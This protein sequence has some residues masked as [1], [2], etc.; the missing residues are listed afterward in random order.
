MAK[1]KTAP[2]SLSQ[3]DNTQIQQFLEHY[4]QFAENL[5]TGTSQ[6]QAE[7]VL[8]EINNLSEAA[9][10]GLLK[11][12]VQER[13]IDAA[14]I[15][16]AINELSPNKNV[17][18]EAKRALIQLQEKKVFPGWRPPLDQMPAF[19]I[20]ESTN[21]P[22]FWKGI[23]TDSRDVGEMQLLLFF[24]QGENYR[25]VRVFGFL[26]E[27]YRDGVKDCFTRVESKRSVDNF[28]SQMSMAMAEVKTRSCSLAEGR[29]LILEALAV[30]K[31][32]GTTPHR[33]YRLNLSLINSLIL[34]APGVDE[35]EEE[36]VDLDDLD[37]VDEEDEEDLEGIDIHG[38]EPMQVV[39]TFVESWVDGDFDTA[40][41]LLSSDSPL[42]QGLSRDEWIERRDAWADE[43][44]PDDLEPN[45]IYER[46]PKKS[47]IWLP[48]P[49]S[50]GRSETLKE[51]EAGWSIEVDDTPLDDTLP[52]LPRATIVYEE[53]DR[54]WFWTSYTLIQEDDDWRIQNVTDEGSNAEGLSLAELQKKVQE[55]DDLLQ[56]LTKKHQPTDADAP[57]YLSEVLQHL[58]LT[59]YYTDILIKKAPLDQDNYEMA[60]ARTLT[61]EQYERCSAY[62]QAL[63]ERFT[64]RRAE[65]LRGF[66][67]VQKLLSQQYYDDE[68][69]E[70]AGRCEEIAKEA[71]RE[72]LALEDSFQAHVSLAEFLID[73]DE[74]FDEAE[75]HLMQAKALTTDPADLSHIE[76]HLGEIAM[77]REQYEEALEH[78]QYVVD[79]DPDLVDSWLDIAEAYK[80]LGN[81]AEADASYRRAIELE[82]ENED[83]YYDLSKL[84]AEN[85]QP[86]KAIEAIEEGI[87]NNPDSA[88]LPVYLASTYMEM[89]DFRQAEIFLKMAE[90]I[91]PDL[92]AVKMFRQVFDL[93]RPKSFTRSP[94][95]P[96]LSR[97]KNK[98]KR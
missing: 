35:E 67:A 50:A 25:D 68:D 39:V 20:D 6:S 97:P 75:D 88:V 79:H 13:Q 98:R 82:P 43:A 28:I 29:R 86:A 77:G 52:E 7:S 48:S 84:Y 4:H 80:M 85:K 71:L 34:E 38:L 47:G 73:P 12:L 16:L 54:H 40:Y 72:S 87:S 27:F 57:K 1:K 62:L 15:L 46:K 66:A 32:R 55:H 30:N 26:L 31:K 8:A 78:Y 92:E 96:K 44:N 83:L 45:F 74:E 14:D 37:E 51:I 49:F 95:V 59:I 19:Q 76:M 91:D 89:G 94:N 63:T 24:E 21:P 61:L 22:R 93:T 2:L 10:M 11:A 42:R 69:E 81:L 3:E 53:T 9:Q 60:A 56:Q 36:E 17:R 5:R 58:M 41:D 23:V 64:E 90:R 65:N 18:K 70:R 33:D